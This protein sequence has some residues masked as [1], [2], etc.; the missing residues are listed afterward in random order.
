MFPDQITYI[1]QNNPLYPPLLRQISDP[2][3]GLYLR[4][5]LIDQP[6]VSIVGTRRCT[7]YGRRVVKELVNDLA[8]AGFGII[9]GLALG[10]DSEAHKAAIDAG[11]YT[12][13]VL[14]TG[15]DDASIY[16]REHEGLA[17]RILENNGAIVSEA[18][19]EEHHLNTSSQ[20]VTESSPDGRLL[21]LW[22][23]QMKNP[24]HS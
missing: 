24:A 22:W 5:K 1:D 10:I 4:G 12:V 23:K 21:Q 9:S 14:G 6:C 19:P 2:P 7:P 8:N 13:A 15:I 11:A 17:K 3:K 16:P 18:K 20:G